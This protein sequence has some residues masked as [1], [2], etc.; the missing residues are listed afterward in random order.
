MKNYF[1]LAILVLFSACITDEIPEPADNILDNPSELFTLLDV[2][3][4]F[5]SN[6]QRHVDVTFSNPQ[7][8]LNEAQK[9][10]LYQLEVSAPDFVRQISPDRTS[11]FDTQRN[12]GET[13]CYLLRFLTQD[14]EYTASSEICFEVMP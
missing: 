3:F 7:S 4:V 12:I 11:F 5:Y 1:I 14:L 10:R 2:D 6:T 13:R 8:Q 9:A